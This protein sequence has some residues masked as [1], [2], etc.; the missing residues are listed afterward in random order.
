MKVGDLVVMPN[1]SVGR[2]VTGVVVSV[3]PPEIFIREKPS[4]YRAGKRL[5]VVWS[6]G[7]GRID[8]EPREWLEVISESR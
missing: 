3:T 5:A 6:D 1:S 7:G 2:E 4:W 8:W